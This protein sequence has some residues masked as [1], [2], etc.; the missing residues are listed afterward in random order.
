VVAD[1][2]T[3]THLRVWIN[4]QY[5]EILGHCFDGTAFGQ[6]QEPTA[7]PTVDTAAQAGR[8]TPKALPEDMDDDIPF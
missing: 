2:K 7:A 5:P 4:K 8:V 3:A 6:Q 1:V